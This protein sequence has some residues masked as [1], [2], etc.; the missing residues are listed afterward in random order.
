MTVVCIDCRYVGAAPSGIG[1]VT[2][3]LVRHLPSL[4]PDI[5]FIFL[6]NSQR[7]EPLSSAPNVKEIS[8]KAPANSPMTMWWLPWIVDF[9]GVDLFHAPFNILPFGLA[10]KTVTTVHDIMWLTHPQ[11]CNPS[12]YG[13]IERRFYAHGI[14]RA[15][16]QSD[17]IATVSGA[18]RA[19]IVGLRPEL[20]ERAHITLSGVSDAF[21][22]VEV[23][24][25]TL[26]SIGLKPGRKFILSAGQFAPYKNHEG[27]IKAFAQSFGPRDDIDLVM[28]QRRKSGAS[29]LVDLARSLGVGSR[30][31]FTGTVD[32]STLLQLYSGALALLHPSLCEGFGNPVAEAMACGCPVITSNISAMPEVAG[33]AAA[34]VNPHD[35]GEIAAALVRVADDEAL[36]DEM[37]QKGLAR[38][39]ELSWESFAKA[40]LDIY[41]KVLA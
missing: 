24:P 35:T 31:H 11:W 25:G 17:A 28:V 32:F 1:E 29:V 37:S 12:A 14:N 7:Q 9:G 19:E 26:A 8:V 4:A 5:E 36:R 18:T 3:A 10:M 34:L 2:W 6:R 23:E 13:H 39:K 27:A 30:V 40:N 33:G 41:R 15:L 20:G 38:A 16:G 21:R 22:K